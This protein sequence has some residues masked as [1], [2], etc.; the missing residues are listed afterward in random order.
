MAAGIGGAQVVYAASESTTQA[1]GVVQLQSILVT[2][3]RSEQTALEVV[4][5]VTVVSE[6]EIRAKN[7]QSVQDL[8]RTVPGVQITNS[9]GFGKATSIFLRGANANQ[10]LL[11]IDGVRVGSA[12]LGMPAFQN[13]PI[14]QIERIEKRKWRDKGIAKIIFRDGGRKRRFILDD[15]KFLRDPTDD[16]LFEIEQRVGIDKITGGPPEAVADAEYHEDPA[17]DL[18]PDDSPESV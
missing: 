4:G 5:D 7:A 9:G 12:T 3:A 8:L 2:A 11:L 6:A 10:T 13:I 16:I 18:S 17:L 15:M 1:A 14:D